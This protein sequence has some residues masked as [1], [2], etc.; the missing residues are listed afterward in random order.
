MEFKHYCEDMTGELVAWQDKINRVIDKFDATPSGEKVG[1][2]PQITDLHIMR[3]ELRG[4][5]D[6]IQAECQLTGD[7]GSDPGCFV[8]TPV[9]PVYGC[10]CCC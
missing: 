1:V 9:V 2:L 4:R 10:G 8:V 3:E 6:A 5:I 7:A